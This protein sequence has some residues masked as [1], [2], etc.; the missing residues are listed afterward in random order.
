M[1]RLTHA[2]L[3]EQAYEELQGQILSG[4]RPPGQRLLPDRL[5]D[6]LAISMTPVKE[7]L[8]LLERDGLIEGQSRRASAVRRFTREDIVQIYEA[9]LLF[10]LNAL[11][12]GRKARRITAEFLARLERAHEAQ[13]RHATQKTREDLAE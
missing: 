5:A 2:T 7:A 8:A 12:E 6:E 10:E 3:A 4:R 9:R 11:A 1:A 13:K